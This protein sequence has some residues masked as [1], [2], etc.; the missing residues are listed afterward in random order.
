MV[1]NNFLTSLQQWVMIVSMVN[2]TLHLFTTL[3]FILRNFCIHFLI[4]VKKSFLERLEPEQ[5]DVKLFPVITYIP[6]GR[7]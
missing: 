1:E 4:K 5:R 6:K 3:L 2:I 7:Y